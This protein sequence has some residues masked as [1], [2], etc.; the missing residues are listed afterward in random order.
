MQTNELVAKRMTVDEAVLQL[1]LLEENFLVFTH[2]VTGHVAVLH[3][4]EGGT[5]YGLID[6]RP[7]A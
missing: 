6:A 1:N 2:S 4:R 7:A 3:R 5:S